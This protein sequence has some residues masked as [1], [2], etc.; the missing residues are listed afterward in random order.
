[1]SATVIVHR[2]DVEDPPVEPIALAPRGE[3]RAQ[4]RLLL[5]DNGKAKAKQLLLYIADELER[6]LPIASIE[7]VSKP[8][9][10]YVLEDD[11]VAELARR[12]DLVIAGLGDCGACSAC[13]LQDALMFE[14]AGVPA[15][16]LITEVFVANIAR[17]SESLGHPGYHSLVV[18]HPAATKT[19]EQLRAFAASIAD[20]A[21]EQLAAGTLA[22]VR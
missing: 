17:F 14:R 10:G 1:M 16:V 15:T 18:P 7:V 5:V 4:A 22:G 19:D 20:A 12:F 2:P 13:S 3:L 9:A 11:Q 6:R 21:C 8:G